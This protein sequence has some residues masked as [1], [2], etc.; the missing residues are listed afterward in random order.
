MKIEKFNNVHAF[1]VPVAQG[2][3]SA[4]DTFIISLLTDGTGITIEFTDGRAYLLPTTEIVKEILQSE[5]DNK[6]QM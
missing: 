6:E 5:L 3:T 1:R 4:G 2:N